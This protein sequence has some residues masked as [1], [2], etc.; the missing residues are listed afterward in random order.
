MFLQHRRLGAATE[1]C[2]IS[3]VAVP[4]R[5]CCKNMTFYSALQT[6]IGL[7]YTVLFDYITAE[8]VR[9]FHSNVL[10]THGEC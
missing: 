3:S 1:L 7:L 2:A 9:L 4:R 5:R 8:H 6:S 10:Q